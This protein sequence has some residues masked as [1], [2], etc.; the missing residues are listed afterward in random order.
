QLRPE[1]AVGRDGPRGPGH[2]AADV[3]RPLPPAS[4]DLNQVQDPLPRQCGDN[5]PLAARRVDRRPER[6]QHRLLGRVDR[7]LEQRVEPVVRER[8]PVRGREREEDLAAPVVGDRAGAREPE[9]GPAREALELLRRERRVGGEDGDAAAAGMRRPRALLLEEAPDGHAVD[10]QLFRR[11][12]VR[13]HQRADGRVAGTPAGRAD[14]AFPVEGDHP[15]AGPDGAFLDVEARRRDGPRHVRRLHV[16]HARV[17]QPAVVALADHGDDDVVDTDSRVGC[18]RDRDGAV[19][20]ATD[21]VRRREVDRCLEKPP[22]PDLERTRQLART[23]QDRRAGGR[24]QEGRDDGGHA[25]A[26]DRHVPDGD[27]DVADRV[28][29]ARLE[30]ADHDAVVARPCH[31]ASL[32][33]PFVWSDDCLAHEPGGEVWVGVRTPGTEVPARAE[34]IRASL[35]EAGGREVAAAAHGDEPLLAVHDERLVAFLREVWEEWAAA[36]LPSDR[37]VP[38]VFAHRSLTAGAPATPSAVWARPGLFAYDT[39]TLVGPGTWRAA[40]AAVDVAL[41]AV[42]LVTAGEPL[43][44]ACC[45]PP[46]HHALRAA[47]GGSCYLNNTAVAAAELLRR[48]GGPVAVVDV[49]AHHGN[50]TQ[51]LFR[52]RDDVRTASVHVDPGAGWFPHFLGFAAESDGANLNLPL[53]PGTGDDDWLAA[54]REAAS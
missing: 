37:V 19:V 42:D 21:G 5:A 33:V 51:E 52:G 20:D 4:E 25:G 1:P 30:P 35:L 53:A 13:E 40:R 45:R 7:S 31:G 28:A 10:A 36:G 27:A 46:G 34:R 44:Y 24:R 49:D 26:F 12:E 47:Y 38:Y 39:M 3:R 18:E 54:V 50:G 9:P 32:V 48:F 41:T 17:A 22:L 23:V 43:A 8:T 15:L 6:A 11:A 29:R 2:R 16:R 14:A